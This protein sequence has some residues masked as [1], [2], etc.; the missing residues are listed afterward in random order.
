MDIADI[1]R[2]PTLFSEL[3]MKVG[4]QHTR[5]P[6]H[7]GSDSTSVTQGSDGTIVW[8][9][10]NCKQ[11][12]TIIDAYA[13]A[14]QIDETEAIRRLAGSPERMEAPNF[15]LEFPMRI[16]EARSMPVAVKGSPDPVRLRFEAAD[17]IDVATCRFGEKHMAIGVIRWNADKSPNGEKVIRQVN[18]NGERWS[19]GGM[20][21]KT[22]PIYKMLEIS[23]NP[24][25]MIILV[26]GEK[27][28]H[29]LSDA[30]SD[31]RKKWDIED[32]I[33]TSWIGGNEGVTKANLGALRGRNILV[34]RDN[35]EPGKKAA[36]HIK[37]VFRNNAKV[38]NL[39]GLAGYD[40][41]DWLQAGGDVRKLFN[42]EE[43]QLVEEAEIE[44]MPIKL[45]DALSQVGELSGPQSIEEFLRTCVKANM[46]SLEMEVVMKKIKDIHDMPLRALKEVVNKK[47]KVDWA[48]RVADSLITSA[49]SGIIYS[50][51]IFWSYTGTHWAQVPDE[52][53]KK[54]LDDTSSRII[55][56]ET[57]NRA[58]VMDDAFKL[59]KARCIAQ[60]DYLN[61]CGDPNPV[62]NVKNG[63][64]WIQDDGSVA[65]RPHSRDSKLTYCL[66]VVYDPAA[67]APEFDKAINDIF[68]GDKDLIRHF[69][70]V[71]GYF[72]S[73]IRNQKN[74]FMFWGPI[75][76]NGKTS[77]KELITSLMGRETVLQI[78]VQEF[79]GGAHDNAMLVGKILA[80]DDDMDK[81][82]SLPDGRI[83]ELSERKTMTA[84]QKFKD[85]YTF[86]SNVAILICTNHFP[87][88]NDLS[89]AMRNRAQ[90][91]PFTQSF[92]DNPSGGALPLDRGLFN[93]IRAREMPGVLNAFLGG[94]RCL[95]QRGTWMEP[96]QVAV[97]RA[98]W[99]SDTNQL[100]AFFTDTIVQTG[101]EKD[102]LWAKEVRSRYVN[103]CR[104]EAGVN[105]SHQ[106]QTKTLRQAL[107][108]MSY[109]VS[110]GDNNKGGWKMVGYRFAD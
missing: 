104:D 40:V 72:I 94:L 24:Q 48:D 12:G 103:W 55:K 98:R 18:F 70:E 71:C 50:A 37:S 51:K 33:V 21:T 30:I 49:G 80:V 39:G 23:V 52:A 47:Q 93:R 95:R 99:L 3:G 10:H 14:Y 88:T 61:M 79:G 64:L 29:A 45:E 85:P 81:G 62:I 91:I 22:L 42:M 44:E 102:V 15:N 84:N 31:A 83:K 109:S 87:K 7:G 67:K 13:A 76:N 92:S 105:E 56:G 82:V 8:R 26:E 75:G 20:N 32:C 27:C 86:V 1:K 6:A 110:K 107:E 25:S 46:S 96:T 28:M 41:Y 108:D 35:D 97:T 57:V 60:N 68:K 19:F 2:D 54:M 77:V 9:C 16:G 5:C 59:F 53:I 89:P 69:L 106:V 66:D 78:K 38:I 36:L 11:G 17:Y 43:E 101:D 58:K 100:V 90:I 34:I 73:P 4:S 63:E 65:L 74:F